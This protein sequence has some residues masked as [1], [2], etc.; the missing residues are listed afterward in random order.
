VIGAIGFV[1]CVLGTPCIYY[2]TEQG[3]SGSDGD[4]QMREAMFDKTNTTSLLNTNC[5]IYKEI[6]KIAAVMQDNE[7]LRFG[8]MYY[9]EISGDGVTFGLPFG[10]EYT[11][12]LSR[13]LY[14]T[15][16]LVAYNVSGAARTDS[17]VVDATLHAAGST[18][19]YLYGGSGTVTVQ[20]A[21][22]GACFV[23]LPLAGYQF[24][25]LR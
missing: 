1:L 2:G 13:M 4:T 18:M 11:L 12:A 20:G 16:V 21:A 25:V 14:S 24:V 3:F 23:T 8:R 9:R 6:A 10:S 17:V 22:S 5:T 15:E 19:T 7:P